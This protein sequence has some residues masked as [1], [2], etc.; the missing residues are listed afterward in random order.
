MPSGYMLNTLI[1]FQKW[2]T[3][4]DERTLDETGLTPKLITQAIDWAIEQ[5]DK[6]V[7]QAVPEGWRLVPVE[8]TKEM[9]SAG[10]DELENSESIELIYK[11]MISASPACG[12]SC[13]WVSV[14]KERPQKIEGNKIWATDG[15]AQFECEFSDGFWC[16]ISGSEFTHWMPLPPAPEQVKGG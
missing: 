11:R 10:Y 2:R 4:K 12:G 8:P 5:L 16:N 14:F 15:D 6:S 9:F 13:E 3:G 1:K 7:A